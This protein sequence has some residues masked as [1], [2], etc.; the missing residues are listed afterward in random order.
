[1][2]VTPVALI[3]AHCSIDHS[4]DDALLEHYAEAAEAW[5]SAYTGQAFTGSP[6]E[7]QAVLMLVAHSYET[8]EAV[9]FA[10][11]FTVA[12]GVHD[13]LSPLKDRVTGHEAQA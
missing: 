1:M 5:V 9:T 13:L 10:N 11:P 4:A 8:R 7:R 6:L 3:R 2:P 12:F